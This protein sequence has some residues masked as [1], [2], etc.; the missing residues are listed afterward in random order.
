MVKKDNVDKSV[1]EYLAANRLTLVKSLSEDEVSVLTSVSFDKDN[2][3]HMEFVFS[4]SNIR[5]HCY[6]IEPVA[7]VHEA[8]G[9]AGSI[10]PAIATT[11]SVVAGLACVELYKVMMSTEE[12]RDIS[13]FKNSFV[14]LALPMFA[15]SEPVPASV[16]FR[17]L[18]KWDCLRT[19]N[20][21]DTVGEIITALGKEFGLDVF[22]LSWDTVLVFLSFWSEDKKLEREM[23]T[24]VEV[25]DS[26]RTGRGDQA[27]VEKLRGHVKNL[28]VSIGADDVEGNDV[29]VPNIRIVLKE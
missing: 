13:L 11:T 17:S 12:D 22:A 5:C 24:V 16:M 28:D 8:R 29:D 3:D 7:T 21:Q 6:L 2:D 18:T 27:K 9:I 10:I 4:A 14:N 23:M 1:D 15:F 19:F 25:I 26:V 20:G